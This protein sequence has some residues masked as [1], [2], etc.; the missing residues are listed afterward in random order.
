MNMFSGHY[1]I[2]QAGRKYYGNVTLKECHLFQED[3]RYFLFNVATLKPHQVS[4]P[5]ARLIEKVASSF[6]GELISQ[7]SME[8]LRQ[9]DLVAG[10]DLETHTADKTGE[11]SA[12]AGAK[13][14]L[15]AV[16]SPFGVV[17]LALFVAQEC[18]MSCVYCYGQDGEYADK[19]LM[20]SD[21]ALKAVDWLMNN[22]G[23][24]HSV[25]I[26]FFGG[27]PM[28][29]FP[30]IK[31]VV[32]Y[33]K[34]KAAERGTEVT[35]GM[36]T[37]ASLFTDKT[38][39]YLKEENIIPIVSF[40]GSANLQN[41]HRP[42]KNGKKGSFDK[43]S[44]NI[45]KIR[46][47]FPMVVAHAVHHGDSDPAEIYEGMKKIGI[48]SFSIKR[49]A[50]VILDS[51]SGANMQ[52]HKQAYGNEH[53]VAHEKAL[54][55]ELLRKIKSRSLGSETPISTIAAIAGQVLS[56]NK[57]SHHCG[58]G[59]GLVAVTR[60]G[61]LYPCHR[62]AG[63][64]DMKLGNIDSYKVNGINDYHRAAVDNLPECKR[65]WA[66]YS[67]GGGC[68]YESKASTGDIHQPDRSYCKEMKALLETAIPVAVQLDAADSLYLQNWLN[69]GKPA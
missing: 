45:Q 56:S 52:S 53:R 9:L 66:R 67:C 25:N 48:N 38:I 61:D 41:S 62:F 44:G 2:E 58:V 31:E 28:M 14:D 8:V 21:T 22:S 18:N 16:A 5:V 36:T 69:R 60:N 30:L 59:K 51:P 12:E 68:F 50:T 27:E 40:D 63:Q 7:K 6:G 26:G 19:G 3:G 39:A 57:L 54:A 13:R 46:R 37:N 55:P 11:H 33:A 32:S 35:F 43:V 29:N 10:I 34:E 64:E 47:V 49:S 4:A 42:F 23:N 1:E 65:C 24:A 15:G 20:T 17:N